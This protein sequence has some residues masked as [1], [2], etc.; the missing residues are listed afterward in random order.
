MTQNWLKLWSNYFPREGDVAC[1]ALEVLASE[2]SA[3][4]A[5]C[6]RLIRHRSWMAEVALLE[7]DQQ[8][9]A[10]VPSS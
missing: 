4:G 8:S 7:Q 5:L 10:A 1:L 3:S 6:C 9:P 2:G